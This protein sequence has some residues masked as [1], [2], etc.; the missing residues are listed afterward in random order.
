MNG[1]GATDLLVTLENDSV[2]I[3]TS[4]CAPAEHQP[5]RERCVAPTVPAT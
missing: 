5:R 4:N 3:I 2:S 1:D